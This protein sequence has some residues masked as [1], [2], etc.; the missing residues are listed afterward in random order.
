LWFHDGLHST[1]SQR[2]IHGIAAILKDPQGGL[3]GQGV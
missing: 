2:R 3:G 1:G